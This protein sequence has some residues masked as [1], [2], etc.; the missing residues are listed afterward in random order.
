MALA[1]AEE[2]DGAQVSVSSGGSTHHLDALPNGE[3]DTART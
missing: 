3:T 1:W 2:F